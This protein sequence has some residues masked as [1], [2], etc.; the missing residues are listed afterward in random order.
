MNKHLQILKS[1]S[2]IVMYWSVS[3]GHIVNLIPSYCRLTE[4][5]YLIATPL[6]TGF[7][8]LTTVL[9][10]ETT[11]NPAI[12]KQIMYVLFMTMVFSACRPSY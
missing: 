10:V 4:L 5:I 9:T 12:D 3:R 1:S 2:H 11:G 6:K 7:D 8:K